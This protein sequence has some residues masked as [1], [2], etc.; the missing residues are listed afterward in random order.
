MAEEHV[1]SC[2]RVIP[3]ELLL[4]NEKA[5]VCSVPAVCSPL[6]L[7]E[8]VLNSALM[9]Q[10]LANSSHLMLSGPSLQQEED[11]FIHSSLRKRPGGQLFCVQLFGQHWLSPW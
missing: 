2:K 1:L 9:G 6:A 3:Q 11:K 4:G 8:D 5:G 10:K 7:E